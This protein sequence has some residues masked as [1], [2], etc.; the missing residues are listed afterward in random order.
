MT[1][2]DVGPFSDISFLLII[3]FILTT[4]IAAF[5]GTVINIPSGSKTQDEKK[6]EEN[7]Q[8]TIEVKGSVVT[9][10]DQNAKGVQVDLQELKDRLMV[11]DLA[12]KEN[13]NERFVVLQADKTVPYE[14]YFRIVVMIQE[15]GGYL[16]LLEDD[17]AAPQQ[18]GK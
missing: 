6:K 4:Q 14:L 5:K 18:E 7:K 3:F 17:T 13:V 2:I 9:L 15:C 1:D 12:N 16:S 11:E 8:L 10:V